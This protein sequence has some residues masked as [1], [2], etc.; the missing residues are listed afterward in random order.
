MLTLN[1]S[2][3]RTE[4]RPVPEDLRQWLEPRDLACLTLEAS[5]ELGAKVFQTVP[6]AT[7][8]PEKR[9]QMLLS[10]LTYCYAIGLY[11]SQTI[12][13]SIDQDW[14]LRYLTANGLPDARILKAFRRQ[15]RP[16]LQQSL[17]RLLISAYLHHVGE[18]Q[19]GAMDPA[20]KELV[21]NQIVLAAEERINLAITLDCM[22]ADI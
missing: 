1:H 21:I 4:T 11:G 20:V 15:W 10:L 22:E 14:T 12:E 5:A 2:L 3:N 17:I 18:R 9:P 19:L 6:L 16:I 7:L 8:T 13:A